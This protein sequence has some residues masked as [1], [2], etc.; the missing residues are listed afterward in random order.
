MTVREK[1]KKGLPV[2]GSWIQTGN[3]VAAEIL[4]GKGFDFMVVDME[5]TDSNEKEFCD[6]ARAVKAASASC[7]PMARLREN[8][9][10]AIRRV[11]DCGAKGVII[12]LVN[13]A[14]SA[15]KAV[16]AAK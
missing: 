8:D 7:E 10:L 4:A 13:N 15:K 12:P 14:E 2:T 9:T 5:H 6:I 1:L 16:A 11:L 3:T